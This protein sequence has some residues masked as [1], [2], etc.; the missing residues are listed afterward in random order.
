[1]RAGLK[2]PP[3][4]LQGQRHTD[5][6]K[7]LLLLLPLMAIAPIPAFAETAGQKKP[8]FNNPLKTIADFHAACLEQVYVAQS[9]RYPGDYMVRLNKTYAWKTCQHGR[10]DQPSTWLQ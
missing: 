9:E 4:F 8:T 6:M 5:G 7:R 1:M 2:N 10:R 3:L